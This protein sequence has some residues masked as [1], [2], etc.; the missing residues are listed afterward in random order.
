MQPLEAPDP[1]YLS[2]AEGWLGLGNPKEAAAEWD[3]LSPDGQRHPAALEIRWQIFA[4]VADW[5]GAL[6]VARA[7]VVAAPDECVGWLHRAYAL[8]RATTGGLEQAWDAL[9]PAADKFPEEDVV[10]YN[11]ACYATQLGRPDEGWEWYLRAVQ[12][13]GDGKRVKAMALRDDDL[14]PLW[15][16]IQA[17]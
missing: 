15:E 10:A 16:R 14:K 11:L 4:R 9:H 6:E 1:H 7:L 13:S 5:D 12:I 8:R 17:L 2:A 3:R